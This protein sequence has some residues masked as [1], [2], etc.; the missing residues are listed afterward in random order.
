MMETSTLKYED[1]SVLS[2]SSGLVLRRNLENMELVES[3]QQ[4]NQRLVRLV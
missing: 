3:S 4:V 2:S 1:L